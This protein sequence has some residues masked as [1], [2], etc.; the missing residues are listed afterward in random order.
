MAVV[1]RIIISI[2]DVVEYSSLDHWYRNIYTSAASCPLQ[3][4]KTFVLL[5]DWHL[6][7]NKEV[8]RP[9]LLDNWDMYDLLA[10][11]QAAMDHHIKRNI[12]DLQWALHN[13][14]M[15]LLW[16][17]ISKCVVRGIADGTDQNERQKKNTCE[18]TV[19]PTYASTRL[20]KTFNAVSK[21]LHRTTLLLACLFMRVVRA[22]RPYVV[23]CN[24]AGC[25]K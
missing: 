3:S 7:P 20:R 8:L 11:I 17:T 9:F 25:I 14:D 22:M 19:L 21:P 4:L 18:D 24:H 13:W 1:P 10:K 15:T 16:R 5:H 23:S 12:T 6:L 2:S